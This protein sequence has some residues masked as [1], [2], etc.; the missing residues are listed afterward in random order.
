MMRIQL[1]IAAALALGAFAL[2]SAAQAQDYR[3]DAHYEHGYRYDGHSWREHKRWERARAREA[4]REH[5]R[6]LRAHRHH[7]RH[8]NPYR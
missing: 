7:D 4:R 2:P 6:W 3:G 1:G 5:R 8:W